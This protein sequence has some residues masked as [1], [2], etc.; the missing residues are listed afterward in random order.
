MMAEPS[1][2]TVSP[3][4]VGMVAYPQPFGLLHVA[5]SNSFL[6][7]HQSVVFSRCHM[8]PTE[9]LPRGP[10]LHT[11]VSGLCPARVCLV[12]PRHRFGPG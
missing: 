11:G 5:P 9:Y 7:L 4:P 3:G 12:A 2:A 1:V 10:I 8:A 6:R